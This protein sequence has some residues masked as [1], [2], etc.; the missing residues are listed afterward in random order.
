MRQAVALFAKA[1]EPGRVKTRLTT[2]L[3]PDE[4]AA[5][6]TACV[7]DGWGKISSLANV[8]PRLF[9]DR[10]WPTWEA[11]AGRERC[12][13]QRP[14]DLG[15]R[16]HGCFEDLHV[17]GFERAVIIGSDSPTL[18]A[19]RIAGALASLE[20]QNDAVLGP[21]EDGGYYLVGC[22]RPRAEMFSGVEWS[23]AT[24]LDHTIAAFEREGYR[25]RLLE[26]WWD[27]DTPEDLARLSP[28]EAGPA[29]RDWLAGRVFKQP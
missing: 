5:F 10:P 3:T 21:T 11:L 24:T 16:M 27:V 12:R 2:E 17:E 29:L 28:D 8:E 1:A 13:I 20:T 9:S 23:A 26:P 18:P 6:H 15:A 4:A 7:R 25:V 14:G 22:R 19:E